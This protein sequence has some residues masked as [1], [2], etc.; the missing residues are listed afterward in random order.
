VEVGL[1]IFL[2][3]GLLQL[4]NEINECP[5]NNQIPFGER[6]KSRDGLKFYSRGNAIFPF[7]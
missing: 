1:G 5:L 6:T 4:A 3:I 2:D 7:C